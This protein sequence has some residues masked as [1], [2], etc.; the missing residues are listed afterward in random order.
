MTVNSLD[1][2]IEILAQ[3]RGSYMDAI[4]EFAENKGILDYEDIIDSLHPQIVEKVKV[5]AI[6]KNYVPA[7]KI[8]NDFDDFFS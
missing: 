4:L 2:D 5:E 8:E 6:K 1:L 3:K 7:M